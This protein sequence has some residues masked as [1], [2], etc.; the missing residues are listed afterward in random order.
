MTSDGTV[1]CAFI[2]LC[3]RV[4]EGCGLARERAVTYLELARERA[5]T[6]L[7]LARRA[8]R[9]VGGRLI[10]RVFALG[11]KLKQAYFED[12]NLNYLEVGGF[13]VLL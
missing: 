2:A 7:E 13:V 8:V 10:T 9:A 5:V 1:A 12:Y 3:K 4:R 11:K 6:Y